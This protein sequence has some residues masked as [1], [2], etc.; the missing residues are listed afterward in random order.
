MPSGGANRG[1][2]KTLKWLKEHVN[3]D[4]NDCLIWPF[5]RIPNGYGMFGYLGKMYYAHRYMCE[6]VN[7]PPP[8][9]HEAAHSCGNGKLGCANPKHLSWKTKSENRL[10]ALRHGTGVR[11]RSG[12]KGSLT[13]EQVLAIRRLKG[14]ETQDRIAEMFNISA[15]RVRAIFTGKIYRRV[16]DPN[17]PS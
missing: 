17:V 15:P 1:T 5:N 12:P 10:D 14:Q 4:G 3:H 2:G 7:G 13:D 9:G 11:N 16:T 8:E 6:L